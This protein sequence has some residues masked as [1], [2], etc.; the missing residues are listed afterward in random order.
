MLPT[1]TTKSTGDRVL[2]GTQ[3]ALAQAIQA[4]RDAPAFGLV[5]LDDVKLLAASDVA[6]RHTLGRP[7]RGW[8]VVRK[9]VTADV[10]EGGAPPLPAQQL[11]L[12][13]SAD[14]TVSLWVW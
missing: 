8:L 6:V 2:D 9:Q 7:A 12:R 5:Q 1:F 13:A 3:Q 11:S 14:C 4:V 10:W